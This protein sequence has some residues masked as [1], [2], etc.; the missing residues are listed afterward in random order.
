M[1]AAPAGNKFQMCLGIQVSHDPEGH[2]NRRAKQ[3][4]KSLVAVRN[5]ALSSMGRWAQEYHF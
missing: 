5:E 4:R 3:G 2:T 1:R